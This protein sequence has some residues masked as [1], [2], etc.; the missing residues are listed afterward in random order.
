MGDASCLPGSG[1]C[2]GTVSCVVVD[3]G[4]PSEISDGRTSVHGTSELVVTWA[5]GQ[6][7]TAMLRQRGIDVVLTRGQ[8]DSIVT[9]RARAEIA[10][11]S[12]ATLFV[13]LHADYA[14][15]RGFSVYYPDRE[16]EYGAKRGPSVRI[17]T[18][19]GRAAR[20]FYSAMVIAMVLS[21]VPG[22][23]VRSETETAIGARQGALTGSIF[24]EIPV[25]TVEMVTLSD[26]RD[27]AFV[28]SERGVELLSKAIAAGV[29]AALRDRAPQRLQT[30]RVE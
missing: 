10:N 3:P 25:I 14:P 20:A 18:L 1:R 29:V 30:P 21:D 28:S 6:R 12:G 2:T 22:R 7:A 19:S 11:C 5:V 17:R 16:G 23:G 26:A 15:T 4:H 9:N 24:A 8:Q 13:R 27:A